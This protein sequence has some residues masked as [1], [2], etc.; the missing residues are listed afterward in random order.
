MRR[1]CSKVLRCAFVVVVQIVH[2][3]C[4]YGVRCGSGVVFVGLFVAPLGFGLCF[5]VRRVSVVPRVV[6]FLVFWDGL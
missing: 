3:G 1:G 4:P 6:W 5:G 2:C